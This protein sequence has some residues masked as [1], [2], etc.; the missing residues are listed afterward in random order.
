ME[1]MLDAIFVPK[2]VKLST[3]VNWEKGSVFVSLL[4]HVTLM[5][6][7]LV[8]TLYPDIFPNRLIKSSKAGT[9]LALKNK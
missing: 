1:L 8:F 3:I 6:N 9:D 7:C 4:F 2:Y 5:K